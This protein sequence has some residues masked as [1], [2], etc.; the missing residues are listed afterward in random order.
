MP[1]SSANRLLS[2]RERQFVESYLTDGDAQAAALRA[3]Y[4][5]WAD[6][7]SASR[8][9]YRSEVQSEIAARRAA[10]EHD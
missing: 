2:A 9:L 5:R 1:K 8:L 4:L 6:K 7:R 3:G 10:A